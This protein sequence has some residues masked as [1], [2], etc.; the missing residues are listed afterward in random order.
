MLEEAREL[1]IAEDNEY[2]SRDLLE[3]GEGKEVQIVL[4]SEQINEHL[5][6]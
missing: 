5:K 6:K 2:S 4:H 3:V 1:R